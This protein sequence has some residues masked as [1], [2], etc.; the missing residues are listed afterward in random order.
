MGFAEFLSPFHG[1]AH[2]LWFFL[3][4][5]LDSTCLYFGCLP[6]WCREWKALIMNGEACYEW[7]WVPG[8]CSNSIK[9]QVFNGNGKYS[10]GERWRFYIHQSCEGERKSR[11]QDS[12]MKSA[13][14]C[15]WHTSQECTDKVFVINFIPTSWR[16]TLILRHTQYYTH[17]LCIF[18]DHPWTSDVLSLYLS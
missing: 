4:Q 14:A 6:V 10:F 7:G 9:T 2:H 17:A 8:L 3:M 1:T 16:H 5:T 18:T 11:V 15:W 12:E 13:Q